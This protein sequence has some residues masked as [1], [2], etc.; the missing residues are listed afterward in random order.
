MRRVFSI[1][2]VAVMFVVGLVVPANAATPKCASGYYCVW[3][4]YN[5]TGAGFFGASGNVN[6]YAKTYPG[7][8]NRARSVANFGKYS[9][10]TAYVNSDGSGWYFNLNNVNQ[11][12]VNRDPNLSNGA[13]FGDY[14]HKNFN[15]KLSRHTWY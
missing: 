6:N 13:G 8:E 10:I 4:S 11:K 15:D 14:S 9:R 2:A 12:G 3:S 7:M 1:V 5:Y